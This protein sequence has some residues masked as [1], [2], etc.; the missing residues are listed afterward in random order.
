MGDKVRTGG[1]GGYGGILCFL[2]FLLFD[3]Y[4]YLFGSHF[5]PRLLRR[6]RLARISQGVPGWSFT[7]LSMILFESPRYFRPAGS[8]PIFSCEA[9]RQP[10]G[11][12]GGNSFRISP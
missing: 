3:L 11:P 4:S 9:S 7:S 6:S 5:S 12:L 10:F 1:N 8:P 2:R